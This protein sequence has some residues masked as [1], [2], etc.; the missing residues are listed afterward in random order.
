MRIIIIVCLVLL[1]D[2]IKSLADVEKKDFLT[3]TC[4]LKNKNSEETRKSFSK[5]FNLQTHKLDEQKDLIYDKVLTF[6]ENEVILVNNVYDS[7][8]VLDI[9]SLIWTSYYS[10]KI[11]VYQCK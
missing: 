9:H 3:I 1:L 11:N 8:S 2:P 10:N 4:Y 5:T 7:Y 6:N